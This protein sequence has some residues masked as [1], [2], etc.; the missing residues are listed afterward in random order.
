MT[1]K[2]DPEKPKRTPKKTSLKPESKIDH[3]T[4]D[5]PKRTSKKTVAK[6]DHEDTKPKEAP[7]SPYYTLD[8]IM[9]ENADYNIIIGERGNGKTYAIQKHL[10][11]VFLSTGKQCFLLRR[12]M[13]DVKGS[14]AQN[15]WDGNLLSQLYDLSGGRFTSIIY[16]NAKYICV[17]Y[18]DKGK[19]IID[20][21]NTIGYVWDVNESERLKGQSFPNVQNIVYE[22][23]ISLATLGYIPNELTYFLN[24]ISTIVRD[25][26]DVKIWLLGNTVNPYN[27]YFEHF[28]ING[29]SLNQGEIWTKYDPTTG[30]KVALEFC[31]KR[32]VGSLFGTSAKYFAFGT[33]DGAS[34]MIVSGNWQIPDYPTTKF[35]AENS[36]YKMFIK[37][38]DKLMELHIMAQNRDYFVYV[39]EI[40]NKTSLPNRIIVLDLIPNPK[41]NYYTS[42]ANIPISQ[43]PPVLVDLVNNNKIWFDKKLTGAYFYN[44]MAQS[45]NNKK[46][47]LSMT[48]PI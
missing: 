25:R 32:R 13:D 39:R 3:V 46:S 42:L 22:E 2:N 23:F 35:K 4:P 9:S 10:I 8:K 33:N 16:R 15:F 12:W 31:S 28:G 6:V 7:L 41:I 19:P 45:M 30:C 21:A 17:S 44:F 29:L 48:H 20:D 18:D 37:F 47:G 27:P 40:S 24:I 36:R 38:D 26:T 11:E 1:A 5:K 43:L 14:I 34:D